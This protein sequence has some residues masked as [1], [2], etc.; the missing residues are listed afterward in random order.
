VS[1]GPRA[2]L[3]VLALAAAGCGGGAG[4]G[5][6]PLQKAAAER[7]RLRQELDARVARDAMVTE[8]LAAEGDVVVGFR[9][10]VVQDVIRE[11]SA[12]YLDRVVLD[13]ALGTRV[14][15]HGTI[16]VKTFLGKVQAGRWD[17]DLVVHRVAGTLAARTVTV[18]LEDGG[19]LVRLDVPVAL[20]AAR[21]T[22]TV[23]FRWDGRSLGGLVCRDFEVKRTLEGRVLADEYPLRGAFRL[24]AGASSVRA[25]P[26]FP[27]QSFRI[28]VDLT[29][30]S[31]ESVKAAIQEQD[32]LLKCGIA[33][34]PDKVL[35]QLRGTLAKGFDLRLPS[36]LLR[37][38]DLPA[39]VR[40][41]VEVQDRPVDLTLRTRDLR[42]TPGAVWYGVDV[43]A[44]LGPEH[45]ASPTPAARR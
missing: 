10:P 26:V 22:A 20:Q 21:G 17:L 8:A 14:E 24:S 13:L 28:R 9:A 41:Q 4:A 1:R 25:E 43:Q 29:P 19:N 7:E 45:A 11:V 31:W 18:R 12:R 37:P 6:G 15:E 35:A 16:D 32:Q 40:Q 27:R 39:A 23:G 33:L 36:A 2:A 38:V 42:I 34:D 3:V 5:I 44:G 30:E